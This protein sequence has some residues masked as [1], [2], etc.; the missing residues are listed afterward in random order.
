MMP[1]GAGKAAEQPLPDD[2]RVAL[3]TRRPTRQGA[4]HGDPALQR[5]A[6]PSERQHTAY[7]EL[8]R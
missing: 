3:A 1:L 8:R 4:A 5:R 6:R 2:T 7:D